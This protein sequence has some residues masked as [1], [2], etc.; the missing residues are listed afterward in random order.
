M[1]FLI[2]AFGD[3]PAYEKEFLLYKTTIDF[4]NKEAFKYGLETPL[5]P[6]NH[7]LF[8][9]ISPT[10]L[11]F[12]PPTN[13]Y[14]RIEIDLFASKTPKA[15]ENFTALC[16]GFQKK[17]INLHYKNTPI[18]RIVR[19]FIAQG[20]DVTR[21][22]G[23]GGESIF[24]SSTF[25]DEPAGLKEKFKRGS[26]G[27]ANKGK[28]SNS[29]QFFICLSNDSASKLNGKYV[30][31]GEVKEEFLHV[32]DLLNECSLAGNENP[33]LSIAIHDCGI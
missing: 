22:D 4:V 17:S 8:Q 9:S 12:Q 18:H 25:K 23:S 6:E 29:S 1:P 30:C 31:F 11:L 24:S 5:D 13:I 27:M 7:E 14:H 3:I 32:L 19:D 15:C 28:N 33:T 26:V 20:G 21:F 16:K 10:P 2:L